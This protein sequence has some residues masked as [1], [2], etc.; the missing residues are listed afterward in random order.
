LLCN[1]LYGWKRFVGSYFV[2]LKAGAGAQVRRPATMCFEVRK[3]SKSGKTSKSAGQS[4]V[5]ET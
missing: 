1:K 4:G 5:I 2:G 3:T